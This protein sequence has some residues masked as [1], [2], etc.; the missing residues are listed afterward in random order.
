MSVNERTARTFAA[1]FNPPLTVGKTDRV[2][3]LPIPDAWVISYHDAARGI[4]ITTVC[5]AGG[6]H[7]FIEA[8]GAAE[9]ALGLFN[10]GAADG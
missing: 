4:G 8:A 1:Q 10:E 2:N 7:A 6:I 9:I 3:N 5:Y